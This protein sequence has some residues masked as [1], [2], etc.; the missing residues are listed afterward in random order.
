M[1]ACFAFLFFAAQLLHGIV[2]ADVNL[3][4]LWTLDFWEQPDRGAVRTP[5]MIPDHKTIVA[6][7]PGNCEMDLVKSGVLPKP[8]QGLNALKFR[9]YEGYQWLYTREFDFNVGELA[10]QGGA[11]LVFDGVDTLCDIFLNGTKVAESDNMLITH[12][13]DVT[14]LLKDG[15]NILQV[16][17]RSIA[18]AAQDETIGELGY[19]MGQG[20]ADGEPFRKAAY[21]GGWDIFPR[22]YCAGI[23]RGVRIEVLPKIR[24]DQT[25]WVLKKFDPRRKTAQMQ[26]TCRVKA[27]FQVLGEAKIF[28]RLQRDGKVF[29]ECS[30]TLNS[31]QAILPYWNLSGFELWWPKGMGG[32]PLYEAIIEIQDRERKVLATHCEKIGF[33]SIRLEREDIYGK[34]RPGKFLFRVNGEPCYVRGVNWVPTD[35]LPSRQSGRTLETLSLVDDLN[36]NMVRVWGGGVYE[37][38]EFFDFCDSNGIM[39]WQDFMTGCSVFPQSDRFA[40]SMREEVLSVV[41]KLRNRA[42]L[43]LWSGNNENDLAVGWKAG[44]LGR[45]P[46][47]ER[48]SRQTIPRVLYEFDVMHDYLPSSPYLSPDVIAGIAEPSEQHLWGARLYYK[49]ANYTNAPC[50]FA[51]EMGYHGCPGRKSLEKMMTAECVYPWKNRQVQDDMKLDWNDEWRFK[52][53][54]PWAEHD[55]ADETLWKRN[56]LMLKQVKIM[57]G[58]VPREL[59]DFIDASQIVQAEAMKTF[60]E[61]FRS[62][63]FMKKNG[64]IWWNVRDGWPQISDAIVDYYGEKKR[65]YYAIRN[66]QYNQLVCVTDDGNVTAVNDTRED[67]RGNACVRD[68]ETKRILLNESYVVPRN[69]RIVIGQVLMMGQGVLDLSYRQ[70]GEMH[71]NWFLYGD[72]PFDYSKVKRWLEDFKTCGQEL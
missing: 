50:W 33:R 1:R 14:S 70:G 27:P 39:V 3:N 28:W 8:E 32:H 30:R 38:D 12:R 71:R 64:L 52:A 21:M 66:S 2:W 42:S 59:D 47:Q 46:N 18:I 17:I 15:H 48:I 36:C 20:V 6:T 57:F 67:V 37:E 9:K 19:S 55:L 69:S 13:Y 34:D 35:A 43:A 16:L 24:I 63:K 60:V 68:C 11:F 61:L 4:G 41:L 40:G 65:A 62:K 45:D 7:V 22:L 72:P 25:A 31:H 58:S 10:G 54:N 29:A 23:W 44:C 49:V 5:M 53:S 51:S 26:A 56:D